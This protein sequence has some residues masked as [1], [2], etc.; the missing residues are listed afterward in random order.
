MAP[1]SEIQIRQQKHRLMQ[2]LMQGG[3]RELKNLEGQLRS[4]LRP[5]STP[6]QKAQ[7]CLQASQTS[8]SLRALTENTTREIRLAS[9]NCVCRAMAKLAT[10]AVRLPGRKA[11]TSA[12]LPQGL[13]AQDLL[14]LTMKLQV[15]Q[16]TGK[17]S[18]S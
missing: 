7:V 9:Q 14:A 12:A 6:L 1:S 16:P 17:I 4:S 8:R 3:Q 18:S 2:A 15:E 5:G 11:A 13:S 10:V